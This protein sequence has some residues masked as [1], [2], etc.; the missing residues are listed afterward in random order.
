MATKKTQKKKVTKKSSES[1]PSAKKKTVAAKTNTKKTA[2]KSSASEK[3]SPND[4]SKRDFITLAAGATAGL[5]AACVGVPIVSSMTPAKDVLA[6]SS[7]E[8]DISGMSPGEQK[9]VMWQGKP[10]FVKRRT[11]EEIKEAEAAELSELPDPQADSDR[12]KENKKEWLVVVGVCTHLGC[13]PTD[14]TGDYE[15]WFCPC[16]GSHY[17]TSGRIRKGPAPKNLPVPPYE[18]VNDTTI[19][20]G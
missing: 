12:V 19:K 1:K 2:S 15:A 16:H 17:D 3:Q 8:V 5:G 6:L 18:F 4:Q 20:I 13:I 9:R 14:G 7:T 10:I 11:E